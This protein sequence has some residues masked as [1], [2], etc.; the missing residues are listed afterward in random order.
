MLW[1]TITPELSPKW[2]SAFL[3]RSSYGPKR[4]YIDVGPTSPKPPRENRLSRIKRRPVPVQQPL[5]SLPSEVADEI[6]SH[7]TRIESLQLKGN[8]T[9]VIR[10]LKSL[11]GSMTLTSLSLGFWDESNHRHVNCGVDSERDTSLILPESLFGGHAPRLC[12]L[13]CRS[14]LHV[15]FPPWVLRSVSEFTVSHS[16]CAK[17][18][19]STLSQMPRLEVL[20]VQ[21]ISFPLYSGGVNMPVKLNNLELL[22][23]EDTSLQTF[24]DLFSCLLVPANVKRNLKLA[25]DESEFS[26]NLWEKFTSLMHEKTEGSP[27]PLHG[28][29][30]RREA[31]SISICAWASPTEPGRSPSPWVPLD[32]PFRLE[33]RIIGAGCSHSQLI[34]PPD[35]TSSFRQLQQLCMFLGGSTIQELFIDYRKPSYNHNQPLILCRCWRSLFSSFPSLKTLRFGD[36]AEALLATASFAASTYSWRTADGRVTLFENVQRVIVDQSKFSVETLWRWVHYAFARPAE[37]DVSDL[38]KDINTLLLASCRHSTVDVEEDATESLLMFILYCRRL[39]VQ[40][41]EVS[42][43]EPLWDKPGGLEVLRRLLHMLDPDRNV[44]CY[45]SN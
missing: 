8:T 11:G 15:T 34:L 2:I 19:F 17:H 16:F 25:L 30:F 43:V 28:V 23:I 6:F 32:D 37:W 13:Y 22:V 45:L 4:V 36:G 10:T 5:T 26:T 18:L 12:R 33:I 31:R 7:V 35:T 24:L 1:S 40:V 9:D 39:D 44:I 38:R 41:F 42:L 20:R 14:N 29:H 3:Q 27:Y 21:G